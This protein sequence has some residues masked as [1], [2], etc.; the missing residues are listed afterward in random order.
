MMEY[1]DQYLHP[2]IGD[3][4]RRDVAA[5]RQEQ[6]AWLRRLITEQY[7]SWAEKEDAILEVERMLGL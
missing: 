5:W 4:I 1:K 2:H 7:Q 3:E 6:K